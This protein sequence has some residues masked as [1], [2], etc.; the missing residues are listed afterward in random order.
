[1]FATTKIQKGEELR[2]NQAVA[3]DKLVQPTESS[4]EANLEE[5]IYDDDDTLTQA[6]DNG[7]VPSFPH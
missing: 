6:D 2:L 3:E 1:M 5:E 4:N 7:V